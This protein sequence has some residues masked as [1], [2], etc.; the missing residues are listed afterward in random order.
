MRTVGAGG[1]E[2]RVDLSWWILFRL[3]NGEAREGWSLG[4]TPQ[5][6]SVTS[7]QVNPQTTIHQSEEVWNQELKNPNVVNGVDHLCH[8]APPMNLKA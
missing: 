6:Q 7:L 8:R 2:A 3:R 1:A 4:A 5:K